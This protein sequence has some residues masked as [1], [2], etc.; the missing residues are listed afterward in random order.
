MKIPKVAVSIHIYKNNLS[1]FERASLV[2]CCKVLGKHDFSIICPNDLDIKECEDILNF[3]NINYKTERFENKFFESIERYNQLMLD[4]NFYKKFSEYDFMLIYQ[5]DAY[6]FRDELEYWCKKDY[7]YIGAP[8][9]EGFSLSNSNAQLLDVAGNGGFSLRKIKSFIDIL[10][11]EKEAK[12]FIEKYIKDGQNEDMFFSKF[13]KKI[14]K[15][16]NVALPNEAMHFSFETQ[17]KRL[18]QMTNGQLPFGCHA[19]ERYNFDFWEKFINL[20]EVDYKKE[21][22][23]N[24]NKLSTIRGILD[25]KTGEN[26]NLYNELNLTKM[27]LNSAK[28]ELNLTKMELNSAKTELNST[29]TELSLAK[30]ELENIYLSYTWRI[31]SVLRKVL[32]PEGSWRLKIAIILEQFSIKSL[33]M[34]L[35]FFRKIRGMFSLCINY[36]INF[37]PRKKRKINSNS[38]KIVYIGHS[39]HNKTKSTVFLIEYLKQFFEVEEILDESWIGKPFP[40]LSFIDESYLGVI[41]FQLLP[42]KDIIKNIKNDN[43]VYFPMY[44]MSG[45]LDFGYWNNYRDLKIINFS[46]T[47]HGKLAKWGFESMFVQYFPKPDDFIPGKKDEVFFWQRLTKININTVAKLF[48]KNDVKIHIHKTVD[49]YQKFIQPSKD[50]E[51]KYQ[52]SYSEWFDTREEMWDVIKQKGVYV[53]PREYEGIGMSFLEAMAM[54]KAVV[55]VNNPTMNEYIEHGKNGF[56]FDLKNPKEINLSSVEQVQKNTYEYMQKGYEKWEKDKHEIIDFIRKN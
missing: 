26:K 41:F 44:D 37:K 1:E 24:L 36:L 54:G 33:L 2:Q 3:Y 31:V 29:N 50:D 19:W 28:T 7:D 47:L 10:K 20:E 43:I 53:A 32:I 22:K 45:R 18:Y 42:S 12:E 51:K 8:W 25:Y 40:D 16:F 27:E 56:L 21:N 49:P 38:K 15:D 4:S 46:K 34:S 13:A 23:F 48:G 30:A 14:K 6:V 39:Y 35:N 17:P 9:F 55:A 5:L 52:I 11:H